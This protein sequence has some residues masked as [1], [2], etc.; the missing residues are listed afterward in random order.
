[1]MKKSATIPLQF[2][3][4]VSPFLVREF[5]EALEWLKENKFDGIELCIAEPTK[6]NI[7]EL[8]DKLEK[9]NLKVS[10]I[11]TGQSRALEGISLTDEV[12][13]KRDRA[14][15]RIKEHIDLAIQIGCPFVTI[16]LIRGTAGN[17][18]KDKALKVLQS[19]MEISLQ[20]AMDKGVSLIIEPIN[21]YETSLINSC[22]EA[23]DFCNRMSA[24]SNNG[25][26]YDTFHSN[27]EDRDM[28]NA[29]KT[30]KSKILHVHLADSNRWLPGEGHIN[31][32]EIMEA[33][34]EIKYHG[35]VSLE[36]LNLPD[37]EAIKQ[38]AGTSLKRILSY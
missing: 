18:N 26:L 5:D 23:W 32:S 29:I 2:D 7:K 19:E 27:I 20:Y 3:T 31:F 25:I 17:D 36:T 16:G 33:L 34:N 12:K 21:R 4:A 14:T 11:S 38:Q 9:Y 37:R 8:T 35:Y 1:M 22:E 13:E 24:Y 15:Q 28:A 6:V 10:T 30:Y